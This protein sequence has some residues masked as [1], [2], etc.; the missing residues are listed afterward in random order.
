MDSGFALHVDG[1]SREEMEL[2]SYRASEALSE[3][4]RVDVVV[5]TSLDRSSLDAL[6]GARAALVLEGRSMSGLVA[7]VSATDD[8]L[9]RVTAMDAHRVACLRI[10]PRLWLLSRGRDS[11]VFQELAV[12]TILRQV[13]DERR[14]ASR[15][16]LDLPHYA[17]AYAVQYDESDFDFVSRLAAEE[18][19]YFRFDEPGL[20]GD[21]PVV[22]SDSAERY[23]PIAG[24]RSLAFRE[25]RGLDHA[26][27][28]V[29][30]FSST[31]RVRP[32]RVVRSDYDP[33]RPRLAVTA[34]ADAVSPATLESSVE[35]YDPRTEFDAQG[36]DRQ[37]AR[38]RVDAERSRAATARGTTSSTRLAPGRRFLL[39]GHPDARENAGH[40]VV[41]AR[42]EGFVPRLAGS[43]AD[44]EE[45][46]RCRFESVRAD[47]LYRPPP[48]LRPPTQ[49]VETAVVVGPEGEEIFT[50]PLGRVKVQFHWDRQGKGD[51]R[52]S[53]FVRVLTPWA[54]EGWGVQ[55]VPRVGME[56]LVSFLGGD[57]D[58]PV[59]LGALVNETHPPPFVLPAE[60]TRTGIRTRSSPRGQGFNELA[61]EDALGAERVSIRAERDLETSAENDRV[62][63]TGRDE[64]IHV[65][66]DRE[67]DVGGHLRRSVKEGAADRIGGD[68]EVRVDGDART[69]VAGTEARTVA[70]ARIDA[71]GAGSSVAIAGGSVET[72]GGDADRTVDGNALAEIGLDLR[73]HVGGHLAASVG[74]EGDAPHALESG[75]VTLRA[76]RDVRVE[77]GAAMNLIAARGFSVRVGEAS[78]TLDEGSVRIAV[79]EASITLTE[80]AIA[81]LAKTVNAA[82]KESLVLARQK[83]RLV[84]DGALRA[85]S[86]EV[87]LDARDATLELG[88][89]ARL[90]SGQIELRS[91]GGGD[92]STEDEEVPKPTD[93]EVELRLVLA[94]PEGRPYAA[95]PYVLTVDGRARPPARTGGDGS[96]VET[97]PKGATTGSIT[98]D[99]DDDS[100]L[101][102][103][104]DFSSEPPI[105]TTAGV[106]ARLAHLGY[107]AGPID[108]AIDRAMH[109]ALRRFQARQELEITGRIDGPTRA[110]VEE[111]AG[112]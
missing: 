108:G 6:L 75:D 32:G 20:D 17:R 30:S 10:V 71:V 54:G 102:V 46:F 58:R 68:L 7:S 89:R 5:A 29:R 87:R 11:R 9:E 94:D 47:V 18:G 31:R 91:G 49:V 78:I 106:K 23:A 104:L 79:G 69:V 90:A 62:A 111:L 99:V 45:T 1:V 41:R 15:F 36:V 55:C 66:R 82:A 57:P 93:E 86:G 56:V 63:K 77:G 40:V 80:D 33:L 12:P 50:D 3:L 25:A 52:S 59:I 14:V 26:T 73:A 67:I 8:R 98:L 81:I 70:G 4:W 2:V 100:D 24:A 28:T 97:I 64:R 103:P 101:V 34:R 37:S 39:E 74:T 35:I 76:K 16:E 21:A 53:C 110:R 27:E 48:R 19:L 85:V 61:F 43:R 38:A 95:R 60:R 65:R 92:A 112:R 88:T 107:Y 72:I 84:L 42:H 105:E 13:L 109:D 51:E 22:F 96:I 44:S 83:T